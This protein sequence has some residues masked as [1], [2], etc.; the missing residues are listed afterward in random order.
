MQKSYTQKTADVKRE[1]HLVDVE[2]QILGRVATTIA[3]KL[4]GKHKPTY[5]PHIDAG[6]FVVVIN[7][8]KIAVSAN[9]EETKIYYSHSGYPGG[10]KQRT[11][12]QL[13]ATHPERI[14][15]KA[16]TNM[17]PKNKLRSSRMTRLKIYAGSDHPHE[18]QLIPTNKETE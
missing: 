10:L 11:L 15:E 6:D 14:I 5:T 3:T 8:E 17:L 9:K 18:A 16:V 12:G 1:W 13:R 2:N 4:I 7:A